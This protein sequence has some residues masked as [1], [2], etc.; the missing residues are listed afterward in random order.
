MKKVLYVFIAITVVL[1]SFSSCNGLKKMMENA[2][3]INYKVEPEML[4]M[5]AGEVEVKISGQFPEKY[6]NKKVQAEITPVLVYEGGETALTPVFVQ[7]EKIEGNGSV[8]QYKPGGKFSYNDKVD[9]SDD[10]LRSTLELR[11]KASK[12]KKEVEFDPEVIA[13]GVVATPDLVCPYAKT[14]TGED[15]FVK[16]IADKKVA[17]IHYDKNL[18]NVKS[19]ELNN[20]EVKGVEAYIKDANAN[21]RKVFNNVEV[22]SYASPEGTEEFNAE[23]AGHRAKSAEKVV[24]DKFRGIDV[25][26]EDGFVEAEITVEDW[27]GFK[28]VV[29]ESDL[30][31][32]DMILRVVQMNSDPVKREEELRK[33]TKTFKELEDVIHPALR[34]SEIAV[35]ITL[36]GHTDDEIKDL[37]EN[38][39]DSLTQEELI[40]AAGLYEDLNKKLEIYTKY[41]EVYNKDW[42]GFNNVGVIQ[43]HLDNIEAAKTALEKAKSLEANATVANNLGNIALLEGDIEAANEYYSTAT[44]VNE[45]S[46]G[47]GVIS[48]KQASY[49]TAVDYFGDDCSFNA[50]LAKLLTG[51]N[52][53]AIAAVDCDKDKDAAMNYYLKAIAYARKANKDEMLNNLRTA[54]SKDPS[55][56]SHAAKDV[57]FFNYFEDSAFMEIVK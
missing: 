47:M 42:R 4:E 29:Q 9:Y 34:R 56:K 20:D 8:I 19:S 45:A 38:D 15:N 28:K 54:C 52:D 40:Y 21:E 55:L 7:G 39:V 49:K 22:K 6:F 44:G 51:D 57:E 25:A 1:F 17:A 36:I 11:V 5:H 53:G 3:D 24:A 2:D 27:N 43:Y 46:F 26:K 23:V 48:I 32:K 30:P 37:Y 10:M 16:D 12:G 18:A 13:Q 31:E 33:M 14:K 35:N 41:T 50:G